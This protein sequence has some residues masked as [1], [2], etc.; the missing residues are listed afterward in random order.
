MLKYG[1]V[2]KNG[3]IAPVLSSN[4]VLQ[5]LPNQFNQEAGVRYPHQISIKFLCFLPVPFD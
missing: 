2:I 1:N 5:K 3:N 4:I